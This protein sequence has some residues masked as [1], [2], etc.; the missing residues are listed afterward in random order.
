MPIAGSCSSRCWRAEEKAERGRRWTKGSPTSKKD[1]QES[2]GQEM[3]VKKTGVWTVWEAADW[4]PYGRWKGV[5]KLPHNHTWPVSWDGWEGNPS[6][7]ETV[8][9]HEGTASSWTEIG[10]YPPL[11]SHWKFLSKSAVQ[12]QGW[13]KYHLQVCTW[14]VSS[15]HRGLQGR[16]APLPPNWRDVEGSCCQAHCRP[17]GSKLLTGDSLP[18]DDVLDEKAP[19]RH[20]V[21]VTVTPFGPTCSTLLLFPQDL[22]HPGTHIFIIFFF[23][24][25]YIYIFFFFFF[26]FLHWAPVA[27]GFSCSPTRSQMMFLAPVF[28]LSRCFLS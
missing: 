24:F 14:G 26:F 5:W 15:H 9:L 7:P 23:F 2:V 16:S 19:R 18:S 28:R 25:L 3:V 4:T 27:G 1:T 6:P 10:C 17:W 12:L 21:T 8:H 11:P 22:A 13:S 20:D